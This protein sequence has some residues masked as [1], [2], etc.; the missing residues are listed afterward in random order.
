MVI[1]S[2]GCQVITPIRVQIDNIG[3]MFL[4]SNTTTG[5]RTKHIDVRYHFVKNLVSEGIIELQ[6]VKS[7]E[8][9]SDI[10]TK[11]VGGELFEKHTKEYMVMT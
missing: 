11:N 7:N 1:E 9:K 3:A 6:F 5:K 10:Y 4:A 8:N 2:I